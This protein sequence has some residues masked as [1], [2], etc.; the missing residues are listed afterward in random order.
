MQTTINN[1]LRVFQV[2]TSVGHQYFCNLDQLNEVI[3]VND[4]RAGYF[5]INHFWNSK[6]QRVTKKYLNELYTAN[7]L[8]QTFIY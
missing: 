1:S 7:Q 3:T 5:T 4:L 6:P 8:T 2:V